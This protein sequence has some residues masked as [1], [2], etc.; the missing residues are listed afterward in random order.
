MVNND[1]QQLFISASLKRGKF[2]RKN[3]WRRGK[4]G[5]KYL[6]DLNINSMTTTVH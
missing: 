2:K 6:G 1:Q 3:R 5:G 4:E